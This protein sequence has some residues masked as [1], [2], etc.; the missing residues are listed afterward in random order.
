MT[1]DTFKNDVIKSASEIALVKKHLNL[2]KWAQNKESKGKVI[3]QPNKV[4]F[5][6]FFNRG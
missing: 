1:Q 3:G 2:E 5:L 4:D 6:P